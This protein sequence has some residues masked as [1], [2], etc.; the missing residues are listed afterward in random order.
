LTLKFVVALL[1]AVGAFAQES[2]PIFR[3]AWTATAGSQAFRGSWSGQALPGKPNAA[4]GSW[5]LLDQA[6]R[7]VLQGTWAAD[8]SAE[9]WRGRWSARIV[10]GPSRAGTVLSG[11]WRA[12]ITATSDSTLG[13]MLQR[14]L[15]GVTGSWANGGRRGTWGARASPP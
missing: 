5:A 11:T 6:N 1:V 9:G 4:Q 14:T 2:P 13:D 12:D 3:G 10:T 8:K 15:E 7:I